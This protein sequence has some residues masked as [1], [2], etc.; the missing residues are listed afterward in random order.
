MTR[1]TTF[2]KMEDD[3]ISTGYFNSKE[4]T[5]KGRGLDLPPKRG[6][7]LQDIGY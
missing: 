6:L 4:S 2:I 5:A 1:C 3:S 7:P